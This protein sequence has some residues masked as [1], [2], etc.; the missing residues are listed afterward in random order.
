MRD[1]FTVGKKGSSGAFESLP[2]DIVGYHRR[3]TALTGAT[4]EV[5]YVRIDNVPMRNGYTYLAFV[6]TI[7]L[8]QSAATNIVRSRIRVNASGTATTASLQIGAARFNQ[9]NASFTNIAP[10]MG[11]Y[12][13]TADGSLS[14][15][16]TVLRDSGAGTV[17]IFASAADYF[18]L[19]IW[20][21]GTTVADTGTDL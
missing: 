17:G 6:P 5:G 12:T 9:E 14:V 20:E 8:S 16:V 11:L 19:F 2:Y 4:A 15:I 18:D 1:A 13:A 7:N 10:M 21:V 3:T